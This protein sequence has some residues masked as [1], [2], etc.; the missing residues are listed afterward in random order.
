MT[1]S[2]PEPDAVERAARLAAAA[3]LAD[4]PQLLEELQQQLQEQAGQLQ[5][6]QRRD[7][8]SAAVRQALGEQQESIAAARSDNAQLSRLLAN[9]SQ[10]LTDLQQKHED[11]R[12]ARI[13]AVAALRTELQADLKLALM[14]RGI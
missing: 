11:E 10:Q 2:T 13:D 12:L 8:V 3:A 5:E 7:P 6:L 1:D 9:F 4:L 14:E